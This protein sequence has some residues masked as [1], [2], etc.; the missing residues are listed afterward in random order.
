MEQV[1]QQV[2]DNDE[3]Y[4]NCVKFSKTLLLNTKNNILAHILTLQAGWNLHF[5]MNKYFNSITSIKIDSVKLK[6]HYLQQFFRKN[7][8]VI[9]MSWKT[10]NKKANQMKKLDKYFVKNPEYL[11]YAINE[12]NNKHPMAIDFKTLFDEN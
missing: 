9:K 10:L 12:I 6:H 8:I 3:E 7:G 1:Q 4:I 11:D 5:W 2:L